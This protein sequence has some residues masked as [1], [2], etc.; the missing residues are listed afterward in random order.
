MASP[1]WTKN[2]E[3]KMPKKKIKTRRRASILDYLEEFELNEFEWF[4]GAFCFLSSDSPPLL[5]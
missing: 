2:D 4:V 3:A 5:Y 1:I